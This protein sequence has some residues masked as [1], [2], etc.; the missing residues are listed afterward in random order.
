MSANDEEVG[1]SNVRPSADKGR[2]ICPLTAQEDSGI[3]FSR[4]SN[5]GDHPASRLKL[6]A[7]GLDNVSV[8]G[9]LRTA[10]PCGMGLRAWA[11]GNVDAG[12]QRALSGFCASNA[13]P[14]NCANGSALAAASSCKPGNTGSLAGFGVGRKSMRLGLAGLVCRG[15]KKVMSS[16][17]FGMHGEE[18]HRI[19][20][21]SLFCI[22][23]GGH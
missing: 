18:E 9:L 7:S 15:S 3:V 4:P 6:Y 8:R 22:F 23:C 10:S 11:D 17:V 13:E 14:L 1:T 5:V 20:A 2:S 12:P 16:I 21:K 19:I